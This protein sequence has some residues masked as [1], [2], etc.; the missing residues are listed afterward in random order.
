MGFSERYLFRPELTR[1]ALILL[2]K[3]TS[4][5]FKRTVTR[6]LMTKTKPCNFLLWHQLRG[7]IF[8][9]LI[10]LYFDNQFTVN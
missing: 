3:Y 7:L 4:S 2:F 8:A 9:L 10:S 5:G 6:C 1:D